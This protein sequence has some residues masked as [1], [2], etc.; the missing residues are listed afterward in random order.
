MRVRSGPIAVAALALT[1]AGGCAGEDRAKATAAPAVIE[2]TAT[3]ASPAA[4]VTEPAAWKDLA[5]DCPPLTAAEFAATEPVD[6]PARRMDDAAL[7]GVMCSYRLDDALVVSTR[8]QIDRDPAQARQS[9]EVFASNRADKEAKGL[10]VAD[11]TG[12]DGPATVTAD[13]SA[14]VE[15]MTFSKSA[16]LFAIVDL[17]VPVQ[18]EADI[19]Q[20]ADA[21]AAVLR[22]MVGNLR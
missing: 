20:H 10:T 7:L 14:V 11:L 15:A 9:A 21:L 17:G 5:V 18:S 13:G 2:P 16:R 12:L 6:R 22:D 3:A 4:A 1:V 19:D 8:L